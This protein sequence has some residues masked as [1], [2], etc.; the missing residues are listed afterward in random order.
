MRS[1]ISRR[2]LLKFASVSA[3]GLALPSSCAFSEPAAIPPSGRRRALRVAHLTDVHVQPERRGNDGMTA[4]LH[5]VQQLQDRP[6]L[7]LTGGDSIMDCFEA[8]D[9]RTKLQWDLWRTILKN[10]C[11]IPVLSCIGNHDIWGWNKTQSKTRGDEPNWGKKRAVE[12]LA[13]PKRH[14]SFDQAGWHFVVLDSTQPD[15]DGYIAF[16]DDEQFDWLARDLQ[17]TPTTT[18]VLVMSHI[19]IMSASAFYCQKDEAGRQRWEIGGSLMHLD[20]LKLKDLFAKH[21]NVKLC[22]S[23]HIHLVDRVDYNGVTYLCNGAVCGRWWKGPHKEC[24]EGY[25]VLDLFDDGTFAH[26]YVTYGWQAPPE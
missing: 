19:P 18:P 11:S 12:M 5:H 1:E 15:G 20:A 7:I 13:L 10:E 14:Y 9:A 22:L 26:K 6:E 16:V 25:A 17:A 3:A 24:N 4:C 2:D 23:G 21:R 8:D